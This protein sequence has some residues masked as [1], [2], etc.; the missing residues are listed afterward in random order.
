VTTD[1]ALAETKGTAMSESKRP[2]LGLAIA[3]FAL[4]MGQ[5][6]A[7]AAFFD[8]SN[9]GI[10][11][12]TLAN[13]TSAGFASYGPGAAI[14]SAYDIAPTGSG[15]DGHIVSQVMYSSS[16]NLY[17]YMYQVQVSST[18]NP[19]DVSRLEVG[20]TQ[21]GYAAFNNGSG[22]RYAYEMD[23]IT[24]MDALFG[25]TTADTL[26]EVQGYNTSSL[27]RLDMSYDPTV[28]VSGTNSQVVVVFSQLQPYV[29]TAAGLLDGSDAQLL[30]LVYSPVPEPASIVVMGL[31]GVG[32]FGFYRR[33]QRTRVV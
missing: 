8:Y 13:L 17:A 22:N 12:I 19:G 10:Q 27:S 33:R 11:S 30:P 24:G 21:N 29:G 3:A 5:Q 25:A 4:V 7:A 16:L 1:I 2:I 15:G 31:G 26:H 14:S 18:A 6:K 20:W 23:D 32:V 9:P 28:L